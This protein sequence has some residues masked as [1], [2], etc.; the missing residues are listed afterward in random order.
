[1]SEYTRTP[2]R[3]DEETTPVDGSTSTSAGNYQKSEGITRQPGPVDGP[4]EAMP[5]EQVNS[6]SIEIIESEPVKHSLWGAVFWVLSI[7]IFIWLFY[8]VTLAIIGA[9]HQSIW[10][11]LLL[12]V[13]TCLF[14]VVLFLAG[15]REYKA[16]R[17]IDALADRHALMRMALASDNLTAL[18]DTLEPTLINL[19]QRYSS[20]MAEFEEAAKSRET[21]KDYLKQFENIVLMQL[22]EEVNATTKRSALLAGTVVAIVPHPALDAG[23]ALW[24]ATALIRKIGQIYG[25]EPTGLSSLRLLKH[26]IATAIIAAGT[27][28]A[29]DLTLE[30]VG[31]E[32]ADQVS[33]NIGKGV[34]GGAVTAWRLFRLGNYAQK[35]CRPVTS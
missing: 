27:E 4:T 26:S 2:G 23:V 35:L 17:A 10:V 22:D 13:I 21:A 9:W 12:A 34:A 29:I 19:R 24:R 8:E 3:V 18:R 25:L 31:Q 5:G 15:R 33:A 20:L 16:F 6:Q 11:A 30:Q 7:N 1:M 28:V 32:V 14:L